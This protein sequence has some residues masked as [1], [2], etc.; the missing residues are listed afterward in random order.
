MIAKFP[1]GEDARFWSI[2]NRQKC[3]KGHGYL[4]EK[5]SEMTKD[6]S[7]AGII[8]KCGDCNFEIRI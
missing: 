1:S 6:G 3:P 5:T 4:W 7:F 2:T 8:R